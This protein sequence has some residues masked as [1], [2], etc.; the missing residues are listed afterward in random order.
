MRRYTL[1]EQEAVSDLKFW[2]LWK[3]VQYA[4][5]GY[6][7]ENTLTRILTGGVGQAGHKILCVDMPPRAWRI[8][9]RVFSLDMVHIEALVA[10]YCLPL[11]PNGH[12]FEPREIAPLL[13][14]SE[15][16]Y[17]H[18]IGQARRAYKDRLFVPLAFSTAEQSVTVM[19]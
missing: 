3:G 18:R 6:S 10:R 1:E 13:G 15:R 9:G 19:M 8:N 7:P 17:R 16:L 4:A 14:I 11:K 2:G 5:E 12:T